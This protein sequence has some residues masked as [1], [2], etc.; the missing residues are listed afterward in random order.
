MTGTPCASEV[1]GTAERDRD[2]GDE[3]APT[4]PAAR[5]VGG[6]AARRARRRRG[7]GVSQPSSSSSLDGP[8]QRLRHV[9]ALHRQPEQLRQL[10]GD[11]EDA[12]A[13]DEADEHGPGEELGDEPEPHQPGGDEHDAGEEGEGGE[14]RRV[15]LVRELAGDRDEDRRGGDRD[16]RARADVELRRTCRRPRTRRLR[17]APRRGPPAAARPASAAY[18]TACG[19]STA[20]TARPPS[21]VAARGSARS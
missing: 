9:P 7:R 20:Q 19:T 1:E 10:A 5:S 18:A 2:R 6:R 8:P 15:L 13:A 21:E 17:R 11:D 4:G 12:D 3:R 16:R 14:Q